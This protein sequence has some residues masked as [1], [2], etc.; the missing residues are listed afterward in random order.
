MLN[1]VHLLFFGNDMIVE[2]LVL[3]ALMFTYMINKGAEE[4]INT[5]VSDGCAF[6]LTVDA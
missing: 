3:S 5:C 4:A 6:Y 2:H 1:L